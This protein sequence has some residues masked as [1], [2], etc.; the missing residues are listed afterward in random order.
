MKLADVAARYK[1]DS[2]QISARHTLDCCNARPSHSIRIQTSG[3]T[4]AAMLHR[5]DTKEELRTAPKTMGR[6][7]RFILD[8]VFRS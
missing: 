8:F 7:T 5:G 2:F 1:L 3:P 6:S 4:I